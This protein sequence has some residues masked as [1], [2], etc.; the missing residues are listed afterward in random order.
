MW[1]RSY[2]NH[3]I[4]A[5]P[6]FD[7]ATNAWAPQADISWCVG[8]N[9]YSEFVRF[10]ERVM[11]EEQAI[12]LALRRSVRWINQHLRDVQKAQ[13]RLAPRCPPTGV[14]KTPTPVRYKSQWRPGSALPNRP[15][16]AFTFDRF[17][18]LVAKFGVKDSE[19]SLHKSYQALVK[20]REKQHCSWTEIKKKIERAKEMTAKSPASRAVKRPRLPLTPQG[21]QRFV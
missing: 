2:R 20:L 4:M 14:Q 19:Q 16:S 5:F 21:W 7:T 12:D 13:P 3:V 6:S 15:A 8:A 18:A 1:R 17:K 10:S 11:S 9:R